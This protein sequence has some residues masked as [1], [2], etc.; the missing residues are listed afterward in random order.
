MTA[1]EPAAQTICPQVEAARAAQTSWAAQ[2][3]R[4]RAALLRLARH[5]AAARAE[6]LAQSSAEPRRR[7]LG[8]VLSAEVLPLLEAFRFAEKRSASL[9]RT[10][11]LGGSGRP[12][13]LS[14]VCSE[15]RREPHGVVLVIGPGNYPLFLPGVQALQALVAG[16]AVLL[17]P[18][19]RGLRS[20]LL[21]REIFRAAG[22]PSEVLQVLGETPE[23]AQAAIAAGV[24]LIVLTGSGTTG[25]AVLRQAAETSIQS[26]RSSPDRMFF[27]SGRMPTSTSR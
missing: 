27:G 12:L 3:V 15:I 4:K 17:K 16:N 19:A 1:S 2:P 6:E 21:L 22:L 25:R 24:D 8:E 5:L 26:S 20:A 13:W 10:R 11:E 7:C 9:L 14:A 23:D 18:G